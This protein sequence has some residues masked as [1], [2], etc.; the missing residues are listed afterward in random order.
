MILKF[1]FVNDLF[2]MKLL[3]AFLIL[4]A[5]GIIIGIAVGLTQQAK[6]SSK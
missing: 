5:I 1:Y 3:I 2:Q 4:A 6:S